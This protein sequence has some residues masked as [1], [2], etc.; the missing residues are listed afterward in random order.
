MTID[1]VQLGIIEGFYGRPWEHDARLHV[2]TRL[3]AAGYSFYHYAPKADPY[4]RARWDEPF[5]DRE[6]EELRRLSASCRAIGVRFGVG[7]SPFQIFHRFDSAARAALAAKISDLDAVGIDDLAV[8]FDDMR[9]DL[10]DLARV[11]ADITHWI[12]GRTK[13]R[14]V[15][16]CPTYYSDDVVLDRVFGRRPE[17][18]L[19]DL[20]GAL[21]PAIHV[22]WTGPEVCSRE[23]SPGHLE[24]VAD[25]LR[26]KPFLWDNYPVNDG[27]RMSRHLHLRAFTGRPW[28]IARRVEAHAVNPALQPM[29]SLVPALTL[30][31]AYRDGDRHCYHAAFREAAVEILGPEFARS[32]EGDVLFLDDSG[33]DRLD[34][35]TRSRLRARYEAIDHPAAREITAFLDG[36]YETSSLDVE[37]Q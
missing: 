3:A 31:A 23:I 13:A 28:T 37:T 24:G 19:A 10:P 7:L 16:M 20:G 22:Y 17:G 12:A 27:P 32:L 29:L 11:Q 26:R 14:R 6:A 4:L 35:A 36:A 21:D 15:I 30:A 25:R 33:R 9:G 34:E 18:F 2:V 1:G 8:L 5:P